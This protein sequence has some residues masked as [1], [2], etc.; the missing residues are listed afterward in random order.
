ME[1]NINNSND[2]VAYPLLGIPKKVGKAYL[3]KDHALVGLIYTIVCPQ[4]HK[5]LLVKAASSRTQ[6]KTCSDCGAEIYFPAKARPVHQEAPKERKNVKEEENGCNPTHKYNPSHKVVVDN[7][8]SALTFT[9]IETLDK[10]ATYVINGNENFTEG[11]NVVSIDVTSSDTNSTQSYVFNVIK[12]ANV[13]NYLE[14]LTVTANTNPPEVLTLVPEFSATTLDYVINVASDV[15]TITIG[16]TA[17]DSGSSISGLDTYPLEMG[18]NNFKVVVTNSGQK[19]TYKIRVN[20]DIY[21]IPIKNSRYNRLY[22]DLM[23]NI[24]FDKVF[25]I[26]HKC[27]CIF[28]IK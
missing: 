11:M 2:K 13:S 12:Q 19:R 6:K 4:C 9:K 10:H 5:H 20:N 16:G 18:D 14:T 27:I 21:L 28:I 3:V 23:F 24:F 22:P 8:T 1:N 17:Q 25:Y 26:T 7:E 15:D